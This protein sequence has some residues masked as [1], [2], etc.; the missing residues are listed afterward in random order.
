MLSLHTVGCLPSRVSSCY[1]VI[2]DVISPTHG[3]NHIPAN[4]AN[5]ITV[6]NVIFA[7]KQ[8]TEK[9]IY[10]KKQIWDFHWTDYHWHRLS[11][12][13]RLSRIKSWFRLFYHFS[14]QLGRVSSDMKHLTLDLKYSYRS[15][16][17][18]CFFEKLKN[19]W[20][21]RLCALKN[22]SLSFCRLMHCH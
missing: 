11:C 19:I 21:K 9:N 8:S 22:N 18:F 15:T 1:R 13:L 6:V 20:N 7:E 12:H 16:L 14:K 5:H 3:L 10:D 17:H 4:R 2:S